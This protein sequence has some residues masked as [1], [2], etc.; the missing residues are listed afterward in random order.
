MELRGSSS[1]TSP[2]PPGSWAQPMP[3]SP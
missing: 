2:I 1:T 3:S